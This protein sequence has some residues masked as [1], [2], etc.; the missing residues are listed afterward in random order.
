MGR[1]KPDSLAA[2][3][4][5]Q[6]SLSPFTIDMGLDR[7]HET[8]QR[9]PLDTPA[10]HVFTVAGT[11]GKGSCVRLL[12]QAL[13]DAGRMPGAYTSPHLVRYNERIRIGGKDIGDTALVAAFEQV[14]RLREDVPLTYFEFG[15]LAALCCFSSAGCDAWILEV[16]MGGRLD[17]VNAIDPDYSLITT[18]GLDHERWLGADIEA[19]ALEKAGIMRPGKPVFFGD[20]PVPDNIRAQAVCTGAVLS[21]LGEDFGFT[22]GNGSWSWKGRQ[23]S[24]AGL[25]RS[26]GMTGAQLRNVSLVLAALESCDPGMVA[27]P[28]RVDEVLRKSCL[29]GRFQR[30]DSD[31]QWILDVAHNAQAASVLAAQLQTLDAVPTTTAV[32]GMLADK[33]AAPFIRALA[34]QIDRCIVVALDDPGSADP[35]DLAARARAAGISMVSIAQTTGAAFE[36]ARQQT[37]TGGR[38]LV[39]GS[40]RII[41]PALEWLGLY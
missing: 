41:G 3:L 6:E 29:P 38:I 33:Q 37:G 25:S 8:L 26:S 15:T 14:E 7:V 22:A 21:C 12:E 19:I 20:E 13:L 35:A 31:Q 27:D 30:F 24:L 36:Q 11:N 1:K 18:I 10:G 16:G 17:A 32:V 34:G 9:L 40:F 28:A 4:R 2:W 5:W 39:C 23:S